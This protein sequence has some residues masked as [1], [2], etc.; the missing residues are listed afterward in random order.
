MNPSLSKSSDSSFF[1]ETLSGTIEGVIFH[2]EENG[3]S[4]IKVKIPSQ[5]DPVVVV[6]QLPYVNIGEH[7]T[8]EGKWVKDRDYGTQFRAE[9]V[10]TFPPTT[11]EGIEKY[12]SSGLIRGIGPVYAKKL[13]NYFG[14]KV[15]DV[16]ENQS[17][18]LEEVEGIGPKRRKIIKAAWEEQKAVRSIMLFLHSFGIGTTRAVKIYKAYGEKSI[19]L[20]KENPYRLAVDIHGIGFK[21]ADQIALKIGIPSNSP[22][23]IRA[24][25]QFIIMEAMEEGHCALPESLLKEKTSEYLNLNVN[26][27]ENALNQTLAEQNLVKEE[28]GDQ[29]FI[30]LPFLKRAEETIARKLVELL[31]G[32]PPYPP[33]DVQKA[34]DWYSKKFNMSLGDEQKAAIQMALTQKVLIITGGPGV[35]KTTIINALLQILKAK[36]VNAVLCAPTGRAAKRL[37]EVTGL[38]A[39][40]IHRLLEVNPATGAFIHNEQ[41]PIECDLLIIDE[42]SMVDVPLMFHLIRAVP[43]KSALIFVGDVDQLPSVGPGT[44]LR[45]LIN[46]GVIPVAKLTKIYRQSETSQIIVGAH[47]I[48]RGEIPQFGDKTKK[49]DFYFIKRETPESIIQTLKELLTTRIPEKFGFHPVRDI[50]VLC[51]MNRGSLGIIELNRIIQDVLNPLDFNEPAIEKYGWQFR[52]RDKVMQTENNYKK[53]VFNGDIGFVE[54]IDLVDQQ[55]IV[56]F[57]QRLIE[58]D[59][60][61]LDELSPAY[62]ITIHKSQGS[63]F[64]AVIIPI[65][66]QQYMLLQR[67]LIYT[68]VTRGK[69]LVVLI[70]QPR[71]LTIAIKNN[72][73]SERYSLLLNRIKQAVLS[74]L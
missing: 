48:N 44:L 68:A 45:D 51:P 70:G 8:A 19:E 52:L 3:F 53:E 6:C 56:K 18:R 13:V 28:I 4:V 10:K 42:S 27:I 36:Q 65:S 37:S 57:D 67:N 29:A 62:A 7:L 72:K 58:Y 74:R 54:K 34:I 23:R 55:L 43:Q 30:Y 21:T 38:E 5:R 61:E 33:I 1:P 41:N 15:I 35:G 2:N 11:K 40:T 49:S 46:S 32:K 26:L 9:S 60:S 73:I 16:I 22:L 59:F 24:C 64:P 12:L 71:A 31:Q 66:T 20:I 17:A 47:K 50:Q 25:L 14:E 63:E 69:K 39:K